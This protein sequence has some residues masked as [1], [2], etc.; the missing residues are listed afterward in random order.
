MDFGQSRGGGGTYGAPIRASAN[1]KITMAQALG[2]AGNT[3][4]LSGT[5]GVEYRY[6]HM[7]SINVKKDQTVTAGDVL[8]GVGSTGGDYAVHL[9]FEM[10]IWGQ[11]A[12]DPLPSV[13]ACRKAGSGNTSK[14]NQLPGGSFDG[15]NCNNVWGWAY[16][17][18]TKAQVLLY[19]FTSMPMQAQ[20]VLFLEGQLL[21]I[22]LTNKRLQILP[23]EIITGSNSLYQRSLKM[24]MPTP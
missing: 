3:V 2:S 12:I 18:D 21:Q 16:D 17:P 14:P 7:S 22:N 4:R 13:K 8:G 11:T 6:L 10:R 9:H 5:D 20:K 19:T 1:G 24:V 23:E 15:V